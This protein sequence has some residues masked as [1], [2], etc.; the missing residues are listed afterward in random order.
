MNFIVNGVDLKVILNDDNFFVLNFNND[1]RYV[2]IL[3]VFSYWWMF[4]YLKL[5]IN[6]EMNVLWFFKGIENKVCVWSDKRIVESVLGVVNG[7]LY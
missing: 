5:E 1:I 7:E 6:G 4:E 2:K 3:F